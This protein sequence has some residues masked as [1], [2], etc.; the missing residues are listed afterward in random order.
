MPLTGAVHLVDILSSA[1]ALKN[2]RQG[3]AKWV[4]SHFSPLVYDDGAEQ[5]KFVR[6]HRLT[7]RTSGF[8]PGNRSSILRGVMVEVSK[9]KLLNIEES[10]FV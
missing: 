10:Y 3:L 1:H 4:P 8:H 6:P 2:I 9:I 7:V 5:N